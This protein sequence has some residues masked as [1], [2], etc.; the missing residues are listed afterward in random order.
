MDPRSLTTKATPSPLT[1]QRPPTS[2][3]PT[4]E[5]PSSPALMMHCDINMN[6]TVDK[7]EMVDYSSFGA[8]PNK[9]VDDCPPNSND[10]TFASFGVRSDV[11]EEDDDDL[12]PFSS[13]SR[14]YRQLQNQI[15]R[16]HRQN[17]H[18]Q[19]S[20]E[21]DE[22]V[23]SLPLINGTAKVTSLPPPK[24]EEVTSLVPATEEATSHQHV[25]VRC[26]QSFSADHLLWFHLR[27]HIPRRDRFLCPHCPFVCRDSLS[28]GQH[29]HDCHSRSLRCNVCFR[30]VAESRAGLSRHMFTCHIYKKS[31]VKRWPRFD[32]SETTSSE[33]KKIVASNAPSSINSST[34]K[35]AANRIQT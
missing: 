33:A 2:Q 3:R 4:I 35:S 31:K 29:L 26:N 21:E 6:Y 28:L 24:R 30:F 16:H 25:C 11:I 13:K 23:T 18:S 20:R 17:R 34:L 10:V 15:N 22:A 14:T 19:Q 9:T 5:R 8:P 27:E 12:N 1:F 32:S 7:N